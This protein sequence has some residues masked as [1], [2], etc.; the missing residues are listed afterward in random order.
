MI[1]P[2]VGARARACCVSVC[3]RTCVRVWVCGCVSV[4]ISHLCAC[5]CVSANSHTHARAH[6]RTQARAVERVHTFLTTYGHINAGVFTRATPASA[7]PGDSAAAGRRKCVVVVGA[8]ISGLAAARQLES[9]GYKVTVVEACE[10]IG[11]RARA[12]TW[13]T[14]GGVADLGAMILTGVCAR[15]TP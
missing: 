3:V 13:G 11:G 7:V 12:E 2:G 6:T 8:G 5:A 15:P 4:C 10:R 9:F 14:G 1:R